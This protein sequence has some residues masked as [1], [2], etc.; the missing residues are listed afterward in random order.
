MPTITWKTESGAEISADVAEG[1]TLMEAALANGVGGILGDCGG[2]L[3][4]ATCHVVVDDAWAAAAGTPTVLEEDMLDMVEAGRRP[5]SRLSCQL[6]AHAGLDGL[7]LHVP[8][9]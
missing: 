3:A 7:I 1:H 6:R 2:S 8:G 5:H 9:A 4:C